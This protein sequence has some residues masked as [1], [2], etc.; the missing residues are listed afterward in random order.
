[1]HFID[2][3]HFE[4]A[5]HRLVHRLLQQLRDIV[6]APVGCRIKLGVVYKAS[7]INVATSCANAAGRSGDAAQAV[8]AQAVE[9]F[10]QNARNG[11][12]AHPPG[13]GKQIGMVQPSAGQRIAERLHHMRLTHHFRKIAGTV[14]ARQYE[15]GH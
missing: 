6:H 10:G 12:F 5:Q 8:R 13:A 1:M 15:V 11:G 4:P 7:C 2:H 14:F 3:E 9:R